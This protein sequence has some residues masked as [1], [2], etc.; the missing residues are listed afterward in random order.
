MILFNYNFPVE[1]MQLTLLWQHP[2]H[3]LMVTPGHTPAHG[4]SQ[5]HPT[6][7][8][9]QSHPAHVSQ[10]LFDILPSVVSQLNILDIFFT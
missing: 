4:N 6:H 8:N 9:F 10:A 2:D 3:L 1:A 5:S 7:G